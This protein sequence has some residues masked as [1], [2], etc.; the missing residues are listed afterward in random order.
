MNV[1]VFIYHLCDE[2]VIW[3]GCTQHWTVS[4]LLLCCLQNSISYQ[5]LAFNDIYLKRKRLKKKKHSYDWKRNTWSILV[6]C[7]LWL[8]CGGSQTTSRANTGLLTPR[9]AHQSRQHVHRCV[10][11]LGDRENINSPQIET[12]W[13]VRNH[14]G[15]IVSW[16]ELQLAVPCTN[17]KDLGAGY[18]GTVSADSF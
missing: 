13:L 11:S 16:N 3:P 18:P 9:Q 2:L 7:E 8:V 5:S 1:F 6:S 15:R 14:N 17:Y 12:N 10:R 4:H